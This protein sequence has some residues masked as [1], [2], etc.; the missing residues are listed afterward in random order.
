MPDIVP[1]RLSAT[2]SMALALAE[3]LEGGKALSSKIKAR[4]LAAIANQKPAAT[5]G[6]PSTQQRVVF[7]TQQTIAK[8]VDDKLIPVSETW[9]LYQSPPS[10]KESAKL[11]NSEKQYVDRVVK[12]CAKDVV[13][14][15]VLAKPMGADLWKYEEDFRTFDIKSGPVSF[16]NM[17]TLTKQR[18]S[19]EAL[20]VANSEPESNYLV[21]LDDPTDSSRM[22]LTC[23]LFGSGNQ[24]LPLDDRRCRVT[25]NI[26]LKKGPA[27]DIL[28]KQ[29]SVSLAHFIIKNLA[30]Q[31]RPES[32]A[33]FDY[34]LSGDSNIHGEEKNPQTLINIPLKK[35]VRAEDTS[36][37]P[38]DTRKVKC[39]SDTELLVMAE[40]IIQERFQERRTLNQGE[41]SLGLNAR[42]TAPQDFAKYKRIKPQP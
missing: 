4:L 15:R 5:T 26:V 24:G 17:S 29:R 23:K 7:S 33:F 28:Q 20:Q 21:L 36:K 3:R 27:T 16:D 25:C 30:M 8:A 40:Q 2:D 31:I 1:E 19:R 11:P 35:I 22:I 42:N 37:Y 10:L 41:F 13:A 32:W 12:V 18:L 9:E 14:F 6:T 34:S 39:E 38:P